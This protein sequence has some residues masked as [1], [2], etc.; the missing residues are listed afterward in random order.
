MQASNTRQLSQHAIYYVKSMSKLLRLP[1]EA[2]KVIAENASC[3]RGL[4][5]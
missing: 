4:A 2:R 3:L 5:G 1:K